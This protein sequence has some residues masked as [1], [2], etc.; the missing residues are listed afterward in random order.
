MSLLRQPGPPFKKSDEMVTCVVSVSAK[1]VAYLKML[2]DNYATAPTLPPEL[3]DLLRN[4]Q[5]QLPK[6]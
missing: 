4:F 5:Q 2:I 3:V 6:E 1:K